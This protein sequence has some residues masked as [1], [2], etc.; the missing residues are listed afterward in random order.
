MSDELAGSVVGGAQDQDMLGGSV[1]NDP[2][3]ENGA[4]IRCGALGSLRIEVHRQLEGL[5]AVWAALQSDAAPAPFQS[6][7]WVDAWWRHVG[8]PRG[9][10]AVIAA[11]F[12]R[13]GQPAVLLPM[14]R[15][16]RLGLA[17]LDW[18]GDG[19]GFYSGPLVRADILPLLTADDACCLLRATLGACR[20]VD[21]LVLE[22]QPE[23]IGGTANPF[24][25]EA[26]VASANSATLCLL[27]ADWTTYDQCH[28]SKSSRRKARRKIR[29]LRKLGEVAFVIA[30][31]VS[32]RA[33]IFEALVEQ[34]SMWL[35][36]RGV[37]DYFRC[38][39]TLAFLREM[40]LME[41][42]RDGL[43]SYLAAIT[44][45][46]RPIAE[47]FGLLQGERLSAVIL[48]SEFGEVTR[49]SVGEELI[50]RILEWCSGHGIHC[51]DLGPGEGG[52]KD[53]WRDT[54]LGL[55]HVAT[56][57][58]VKGRLARPLFLAG[59]SAKRQAKDSDSVMQLIHRARSYW[60]RLVPGAA[61]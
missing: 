11:F 42:D 53:R 54:R 13:R 14:M 44:L 47:L 35:E 20:R 9:H 30:E 39:E 34:K 21:L 24:L 28:R 52:H 48:A 37:E 61:H 43:R 36:E 7:A 19:Q 4:R 59:W 26:P 15:V 29:A 22:R 1:E 56:P 25:L 40:A 45:D 46:G 57:L 12:D 31:D 23:R 17:S 49:Y 2:G 38:P 8:R 55:W 6:F 58:T 3:L 16:R 18:M 60:A 27:P 33:R 32:T 10:E 41:G 5:S 51:C 50:S